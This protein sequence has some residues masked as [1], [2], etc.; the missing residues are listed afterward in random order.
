MSE[1][2]RLRRPT[3]RRF[4]VRKSGADPCE[5]WCMAADQ[6]EEPDELPVD[7][8]LGQPRMVNDPPGS[9]SHKEPLS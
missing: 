3:P 1:L 7:P 9:P 2:R 4:A 8:L 6:H 5:A